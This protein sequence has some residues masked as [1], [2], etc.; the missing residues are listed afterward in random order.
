MRDDVEVVVVGAGAAGIGAARALEAA[1]I[2]CLVLE[3]RDRIGGRAFTAADG[4][5]EP[6]DLGCG[7]LHSGTRNPW[8]P[9]VEAMGFTVNRSSPPWSRRDGAL[10]MSPAEFDAFRGAGDALDE[11]LATIRTQDADRPVSDFLEPGN[12][13][14]P[15]MDAISTYYS[16]AEFRHVSAVDL[17]RYDDAGVNW[18]VAEGYGRAVEHYAEGL[19]VVLD[20][21]VTAIR[22]GGRRL[23]VETPR[24]TVSADAAIVTL[25]SDLLAAERIRFDPPLP[26][27]AEAARG[28]PLGLADKL[29]LQLDRADGFEA[30]MRAFGRTDTARTAAYHFR[31]LGHS[32]VECYFGGELAR[33]L[34]RGGE[35]AFLDFALG[36]L[37][38][39]LGSDFARRVSPL[40]MH[41]WGA[42]PLSLGSYSYAV[43]GKADMRAVLAAPVDERLFFAGEACSRSDFST[44]HGA[45]LTGREAARAAIAALRGARAS[46]PPEGVGA[47]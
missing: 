20:C 16:G 13:W 3:A 34:E 26:E 28:L 21:T 23:A 27:K 39:L 46:A 32:Q 7:W 44:A 12:R 33:E 37:T 14:N 1:G 42:D 17:D 29:Y 36:E 24:G 19:A 8:V 43:P 40:P 4:R 30:D 5:G 45:L 15:L 38:G 6:I 18:R 11:R 31:P 2:S 35:A 22:H 9:L 10:D 25:P 47:G 41:L